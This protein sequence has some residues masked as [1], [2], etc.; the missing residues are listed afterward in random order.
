MQDQ[1]IAIVGAG[2]SGLVCAINLEQA[3]F[4][5]QLFEAT[6][7][8]G[9]R[10]KSDYRDGYTFDHG[11]Q[12]LLTQYPAAQKYLNFDLLE[13]EHFYSGAVIYNKGKLDK[14]GD[15]LRQ[16]SLLLPT[17]TSKIGNVADKLKVLKLNTELKNKSFDDIFLAEEKTTLQYLKNYGFSEDII[18]NFF[19]PFFTGI[20]LE[21]ELKTSSRKFEFVYKMFGKGSAAIPKKGIQAIP[22]Q[23]MAQLKQT[24]IHFNTPVKSI[25][26][27][28][29]IFENGSSKSFDYVIIATDASHLIPN[30]KK[31][32]ILWKSVYN[33]YVSVKQRAFKEPMIAL[34]AD[35]EAL[36]NNIYYVSNPN[37]EEHL[38]SVSI[39]KPHNLSKEELKEKITEDLRSFA[40][41][42]T[43]EFKQCYHIEKALPVM[44]TVSYMLPKSETQLKDQIFLAGDHLANG[45]LNAAMLN[46]ESAAQAVISK[47]KDGIINLG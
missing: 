26:D 29:I 19:K 23:L 17:L 25:E 10:V 44:Q 37:A 22:N 30:L 13:L 27:Q 39:V 24:K 3:G 4:R 40:G 36:V 45:S 42:D 38:L 9:G 31:Q 41:I 21:H 32:D 12:V 28:E 6:D 8:V 43:V 15:P 33:Y 34:I 47:I 20:F 7:R 46:G 11:F 16:F 14:I 2:L 18:Y 35:D 5:P 1:K